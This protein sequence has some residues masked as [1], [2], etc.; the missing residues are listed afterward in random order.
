[1]HVLN[2]QSLMYQ[3]HALR[4]YILPDAAKMNPPGESVAKLSNAHV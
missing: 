3:L 4:K 2:M 1:M